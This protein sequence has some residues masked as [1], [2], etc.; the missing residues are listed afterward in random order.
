MGAYYLA[1]NQRLTSRS[2]HFL[3]KYHHFWEAVRRGDVSVEK[4]NTHLQNADYLTKG[5]P[6]EVF[7]QN[8]RRLQGWNA[9]VNKEDKTGVDPRSGLSPNERE[10]EETHENGPNSSHTSDNRP[11]NA[12]VRADILL[13]NPKSQKATIGSQSRNPT[14]EVK[15]GT[16]VDVS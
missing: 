13:G 9:S 3:I 10:S 16:S 5:L 15:P 4:I 11:E 14:D 2:K 6:H 1:T 12:C 7:H 8:R